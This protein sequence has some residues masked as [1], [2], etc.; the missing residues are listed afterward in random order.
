MVVGIQ[1]ELDVPA[2]VV[3]AGVVVAVHGRFLERA[4]HPFDLP[5]GPGMI[6]PGQPVLDAVFL[7]GTTKGVNAS[8]ARLLTGTPGR[9]GIPSTAFLRA[10]VGELDAVVGEQG[11]DPVGHGLDQGVEEVGSDLACCLLVQLGKGELAGAVDG[12]EQVQLARLGADLGDVDVEGAD[13][14]GL[15]ALLAWLLAF[16][17]RQAGDAVTLQAAVQAGTGQPGD[18]GLQGIQAV[19]EGQE[20]VAA[21]GDDHGLL[22]GAEHGGLRLLGPRLKTREAVEFGSGASP[23]RLDV[24]QGTSSPAGCFRAAALPD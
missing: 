2:Q 10:G 22:L 3:M 4:V 9:R 21:E 13:R 20:S 16:G 6:R 14:I 7:A 12:H 23:D 24:D 15:E 11:V 18:A 17:N 8:G 5:V 19:V 1:E